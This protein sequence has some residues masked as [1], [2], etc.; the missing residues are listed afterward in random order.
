MQTLETHSV[1]FNELLNELL[2]I[3]TQPEFLLTPP[4]TLS[5][6]CLLILPL[7]FKLLLAHEKRTHPMCSLPF[8]PSC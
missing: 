5:C 2:Q 4:F 8:N 1:S 3:F 7:D 6:S